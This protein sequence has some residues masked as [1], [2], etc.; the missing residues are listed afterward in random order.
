MNFSKANNI[1]QGSSK[2]GGR[3]DLPADFQWYYFEGSGMDDK[4]KSRPLSFIAQINCQEI[5]RYDTEH[6]LPASGILYFFYELD[7]MTWGFDPKDAGSAR[8]FYYKG[9]IQNLKRIDFPEDLEE[10][11]QMPELKIQFSNRN[12]LPSYDEFGE[13]FDYDDFGDEEM[14]T[15]DDARADYLNIEEKDTISKVLG[16]ADV[17]QG[18]MRL[19]CEEIA[20]GI[21]CGSQPDAGNEDLTKMEQSSKKWQLLFQLDTVEDDDFELMFGDCGRIYYYIRK[22]D[23]KNGN[24]NNCWLILQC[25]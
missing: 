19:E 15:Y 21:Y 9:D 4:A 25:Y 20:N 8:V 13:D 3:P 24:F 11:F 2:F 10:E 12:D 1:P 22:D 16:Y 14:D 7:S 18:D 23:L 6:L 17:I 5:S